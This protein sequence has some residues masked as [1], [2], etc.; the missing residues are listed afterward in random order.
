MLYRLKK[1][2]KEEL[3]RKKSNRLIESYLSTHEIKKLQ[4]GCGENNLLEGWLNT[5]ILCEIDKVVFLDAGKEFPFK[6]ETFHFIFSEHIFEH[7]K[8]KQATCM[9][10]E[11]YRVLK[12]GGKIRIATPDFDFLM[13]LYQNP[14]TLLHKEYIRWATRS[15]I[16]DISDSLIEDEFLAAY[17]VNNF[18]KDWGHQIIHNYQSISCLLSKAG[19]LNINRNEVGKSDIAEFRN[20]EKHGNIIPAEFNELETMVIEASKL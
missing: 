2:I 3:C 1:K 14:D 6:N 18:F 13:N 17:V 12:P 8:F 20:I 4:I 19:F 7:L 10:A 16:R 5:D 11:S 15:F 9:L